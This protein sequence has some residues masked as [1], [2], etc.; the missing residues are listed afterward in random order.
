MKTRVAYVI[1]DLGLGGAQR[2]L[3]SLVSSLAREGYEIEVISLS[4]ERTAYESVLRESG[5]PVTLIAHS[6]KWSWSTLGKVHRRLKTFRPDLVH[7]WLFTADLYGRLAAFLNRTPHV[8]SAMR[9]TID[10]MEPH[11][12]WASRI[13]SY[14]TNIFTINAE[15]IRPGLVKQLGIPNRKIRTI[16]N[17]ID[18]AALTAVHSNGHDRQEWNLPCDAQIVLMMA[19]MAPQKDYRTF[20][21]A[22]RIVA[23]EC[24]RAHFVLVG[25][26]ELRTQVEAWVEELG[27]KTRTRILGARRDGWELIQQADVVALATHFEGCSNVVMEAM[28]AGKPVVASRTGGNPELVV[29]GQTGW[30]VPVKNADLFAK[31]LLQLLQNEGEA[32]KMGR[33]GQLRIEERFSLERTVKE[34]VSIYTELL[35]KKKSLST[36][37]TLKRDYQRAYTQSGYQGNFRKMLHTLTNPGFQAVAAYRI[38]R[39]LL[40]HRIPFLGAIVQRLAE[41]WTGVSLP[42]ETQVGPGLLI[43]HFGG[44]VINGRAVLGENCTL[45]HGVTIGNRRSGGP[46]PRIGDRVTL[47]AGAKVLGGITVGD[48][49]Q[50]GAN[51]VVL[52]DVP[53]GGVAIGIPAR[54]VRTKEK[55][56][57]L[58]R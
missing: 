2:Q 6:G 40:E 11:H 18:R 51:A 54:V 37:A 25:E 24:P 8:I 52:E 10:D 5:I 16:Y 48:E 34:T 32:K 43:L 23:S 13:L 1:D 38:T 28:A 36:F 44:I 9:N 21:E 3:V 49:A 15:A 31:A 46:S 12:R 45:H 4:S 20:L 33:R 39:W 55:T 47:G 56:E 26:G 22:A 41:V 58:T 17:G 7:T 30:T 42:P 50:I 29:D 53:R 57:A 14:G 27:L 19:R 35:S